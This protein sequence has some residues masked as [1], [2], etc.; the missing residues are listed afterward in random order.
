M[1]WFAK[2]QAQLRSNGNR[3]CGIYYCSWHWNAES[4][5][6]HGTWC[7]SSAIFAAMTMR[8]W[9]IDVI[10]ECWDHSSMKSMSKREAEERVIAFLKHRHLKIDKQAK[11]LWTRRFMNNFPSCLEFL[12]REEDLGSDRKLQYN[13][14]W[15]LLHQDSTH[16]CLVY[17][18]MPI[19]FPQHSKN[20]YRS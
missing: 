7:D 11:K 19:I 10:F 1:E 18:Q 3:E 4:L 5:W 15:W 17:Q 9:N 16:Q 12:R 2:H 14:I 6:H 13:H 8:L 20:L